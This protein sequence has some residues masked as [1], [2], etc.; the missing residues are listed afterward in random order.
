MNLRLIYPLIAFILFLSCEKE[1]EKALSR[2]FDLLKCMNTTRPDDSYNYPVL[3]GMPEWSDFKTTQ[4]MIDACQVPVTILEK[5]TTEAVFQAI[6]EYPFTYET[7]F[8]Y[9]HYQQ[10]FETVISNTNAYQ[11]LITRDDAGLCL[12]ERLNLVDPLCTVNS[13]FLELIMSQSVFLNQLNDNHKKK[14]VEL[15][16]DNDVTRQ[17]AVNGAG[18]VLREV[19]CL[20]MSRTMYLSN[21]N[22]FALKVNE[23]L[24]LKT[25]IETSEAYFT[26]K[27]EYDSFFELIRSEAKKFIN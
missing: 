24:Q 14:I 6:W 17:A 20:L 16:L 8:R 7:T 26:T 22:P 3:P 21:Y 25:F 2:D 4:E 18:D 13:R 11:E 23:D 15:S 10:S 1:A 5:Q 27:E 9:N 19:T 12:Y